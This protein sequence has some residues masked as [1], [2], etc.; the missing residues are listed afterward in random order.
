MAS[1]EERNRKD[2]ERTER[3]HQVT[4]LFHKGYTSADISA[5]LSV[6][7]NTVKADLA[8]IRGALSPKTVAA[9]E[10]R[11]NKSLAGLNLIKAE[12]WDILNGAG[13][14]KAK[15]KRLYVQ[16]K[17]LSLITKVEEEIAKVQGLS[18]KIVM[19]PTK[20]GSKLMEEIR[21]LKA[22]ALKKDKDDGHHD[23]KVEVE[24]ARPG[25]E[26]GS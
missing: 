21:N 23:E 14:I 1:K 9:L 4:I 18:D 7:E 17:A 12:A 13:S 24:D 20:K 22:E 15:Q 3:R 6:P 2:R 19:P 11:R 5:K 16:L 10:Y 26:L 8:V 25:T